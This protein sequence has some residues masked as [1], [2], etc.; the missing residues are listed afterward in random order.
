[1]WNFE[2]GTRLNHFENGNPKP[3]RI[4]A[5]E[6]LNSHD[7]SLLLTGSS[8]SKFINFS[9]VYCSVSS[10]FKRSGRIPER[11]ARF[12]PVNMLSFSSD[13]GA[14]RIWRNYTEGDPEL[15]TAWQAL[16]SLLPSTRGRSCLIKMLTAA[17]EL[18]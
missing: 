8:K 16:S 4:T 5:M 13:D 6:L 10:S 18:T 1:M 14:V 17:R 3:T 12:K 15:V 7:L 9:F 2:T 11:H